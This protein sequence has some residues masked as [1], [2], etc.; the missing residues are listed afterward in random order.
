MLRQA[1]YRQAE[2][3]FRPQAVIVPLREQLRAVHK[4]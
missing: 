3:V 1:A 2:E 4:K